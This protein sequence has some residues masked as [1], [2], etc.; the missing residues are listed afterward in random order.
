MQ[1]ND[2]GNKKDL[3]RLFDEKYPVA[4]PQVYG[5]NFM[6]KAASVILL[7]STLW[8]ALEK[9]EPAF[10]ETSD[11]FIV[12]DTVFVDRPTTAAQKAGLQPKEML[13]AAP[14]PVQR[15]AKNKSKSNGM[16][17]IINKPIPKAEYAQV[18]ALK[19]DIQVLSI[20]TLQNISNNSKRNSM[21]DDSLEK[22][23]KFV[24]M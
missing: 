8:L 3:L 21:Q 23:F 11:K 14:L 2:A 15:S 10:K 17:P 20:N 16:K 19:E 9:R 13:A 4:K 1:Q 22:N 24:S 7:I 12:H 5:R 18:Q 6:W